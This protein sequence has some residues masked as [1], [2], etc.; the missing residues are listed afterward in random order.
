MSEALPPRIGR[1][2]VRREIG[3]GSMG[4]VYEGWDP[5]LGR[6]VAIKTISVAFAAPP[7]DREAFEARF[8]AE[9]RIASRLSHPG[10]VLVHDTG[11]AETGALFMVL[12]YLKGRTLVQILR[13]GPFEWRLALQVAAG[14]AE[15]LHYAHGHRVIHAYIKPANIMVLPDGEPKIMDF[16]VA[17]LEATR[18][19]LTISGQFFGTPVYMSP[20]QA[21]GQPL[22]HRIDL[23]ALG[24]VLY[25]MLTGRLAFGAE[26]V[27]KIASKVILEDPPLPSG[28]VAGLP[29]DVDYIASRALAKD[30]E[31]RYPDGRTMADDLEDVLAGRLPRH[32]AAW[33]PPRPEARPRVAAAPAGSLSEEALLV[34][35]QAQFETQVSKS[36]PVT[37]AVGAISR[38][39]PAAKPRPATGKSARVSPRKSFAV[40][41]ALG[42]VAIGFGLG[43]LAVKSRT[44]SGIART[45]AEAPGPAA[46]VAP[47]STVSTGSPAS[48]Q[49]ASPPGA[50][51]A[52]ED[53]P[54][55]GAAPVP[56]PKAAPP[57]VVGSGPA[58]LAPPV[59]PPA[60]LAIDFEHGL[61]SGTLRIWVDDDLLL[62]EELDSRIS[63]RILVLRSRK[64]NVEQTLDVPPGR[65]EIRVQV[66][67]DDNVKNSQ[68]WGNFTS[69]STRRLSARIG[70][71]IKKDLSLEWE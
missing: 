49:D 10:I 17:R 55:R 41:L 4:V 51:P 25:Q 42:G 48:P 65:H 60:R 64:G 66:A 70:G 6:K 67:W 44:E 58:P 9:A 68:I 32:R 31:D 14:V 54:R 28:L 21:L 5:N 30:P 16:G 57:Q 69:G 47:P 46:S 71:L 34:D 63:K 20:E 22:D 7:Q 19:K 59:P 23:F 37:P 8:F 24:V 3:R 40:A 50:A 38:P 11:R 56:P 62:D 12:E 13:D 15:A 53:A 45:V 36:P 33:V 1:Y 27:T 2:E 29:V 52:P 61:K 35:H 39:G 18:T 26:G 43:I